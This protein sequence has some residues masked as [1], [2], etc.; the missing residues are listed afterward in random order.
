MARKQREASKL[1]EEYVKQL[2]SKLPQCT[3]LLFG[4]RARGEHLPYSDYDLAVIM[5]HVEDKVR[6]I[7]ELRKMKPRGIDLDLIV[8]SLDELNDPLVKEMIQGALIL[9]DGLNIKKYL[10]R[11]E[12]LISL[13]PSS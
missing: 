3:I 4:S 1:L 5:S 9:H 2:M 10:F 11:K 6:K 8:L 7:E 13:T 12:N